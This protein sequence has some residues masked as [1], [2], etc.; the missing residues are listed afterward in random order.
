MTKVNGFFRIKCLLS[1]LMIVFL[2]GCAGITNTQNAEEGG[3]KGNLDEQQALK[4]AFDQSINSLD[5]YGSANGEPST[6]LASRQIFDTLVVNEDKEIKPSLAKEWEQPDPNTW[7]FHLEEG[8]TFH[9]GAALTSED[10]KYSIEQQAN[11]ESSPL[12]VLWNEFKSVEATDEYT[13]EI[14]TNKPVGTMLSSLSLLFITPKDSA[15]EDFYKKPIGSGPFS[16]DSFVSGQELKLSKNEEYW[17]GD[18]TLNKLEFVNIPETSSRLTALE[19]GEIDLTWT[20][21]ADQIDSLKNNKEI[22]V[23]SNPSYLYYFNWFN[24]EREPFNDPRVR[25]AMIYA[26]DIDSIIDNLFGDTADRLEAPIPKEV[27]GSSTMSAYEYNPEKAKELLKEAGY[28]DGFTTSMMWSN[29]GGPQILQLAETMISDWAKIDVKVE[30]VQLERAEWIEK[31]TS[32][33]WDMDLQTNSVITGDAD[34][35]LGRLYT[36]AA[37]R[38]G[39][40]NDELD[41]ILQAAKETTDQDEREDLYDQAN[42]IIWNEAVGLFP[43]ELNQVTAYRSHVKGF[44]QSPADDPIFKDVYIE[45]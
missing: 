12:A 14:K 41:K 19:T 42:D 7:V 9:D 17:N 30:A 2:V 10:V 15:S 28:P 33:D 35:T 38:N 32:L 4:V 21:P 37:N 3:N 27:F 44:N 40:K 36:S 5:P 43:L 6:I 8:V 1:I 39:Y 29:G 25:Q 26:I 13:V 45:K 16:V 18:V 20:I 22:E 11:S 34:Y 24:S 23:I 31:L